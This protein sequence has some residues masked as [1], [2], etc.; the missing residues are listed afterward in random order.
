MVETKFPAHLFAEPDPDVDTLANLGPLAALAGTWEG[1]KGDDVK[2]TEDGAASQ[3]FVERIVLEPI[4]PQMNGPQLLY[5]L[6][7][8]SHIVKPGEVEMY[9]DQTGY[10]LWEPAT[11]RILHTL[12]IPRGQV[13]LAKG[14]AKPDA[15]SF[16]VKA[17]RGKMENGICS[18]PFLEENFRTDRF[19]MTVTVH[20][21]G[22]WSYD[23]V[24]KLKIKGVAE[25]FEH[26]D[27]NTLHRIRPPR[28]NPLARGLKLRKKK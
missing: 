27:R 15:R 1:T 20:D 10:W 22:T 28:P 19:E 17:R 2:P 23:E 18:G 25:P 16:T 24:T 8:H 21:D 6:R 4:D 12:S 26:R 13:A 14:K 7:Y 5:G 9:H 3:A 11:G